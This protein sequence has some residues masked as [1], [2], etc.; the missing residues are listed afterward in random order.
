VFISHSKYDREFCNSFDAACARVGLRSFRSEFENIEKPEWK[1]IKR[2]IKKSKALFLLVGKELVKHQGTCL[3]T[4]QEF[5]DW[6]FTQNWISFEIG[7][8]SNRRF[9]DVWVICDSVPINFPVP[10]LN[11]YQVAGI[12][13][14]DPQR[15]N[16]YLWILSVYKY[17]GLINLNK[18]MRYSCPHCMST[19]NLW[20]K[21]SKDSQITCPTCL[22]LLTFPDGWLLDNPKT[23]IGQ[24]ITQLIGRCLRKT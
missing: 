3:S 2:E 15:R 24:P 6:I 22:T 20:T 14:F 17:G 19:F 21:L 13:L 12:D 11:N 4:N 7:V 10:Y 1:S 8:A 18:K 9:M 16:Y 23:S 5:S